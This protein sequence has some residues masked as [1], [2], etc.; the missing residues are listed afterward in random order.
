LTAANLDRLNQFLQ[1]PEIKKWFLGVATDVKESTRRQYATLLMRYF[2]DEKPADFLKRAQEKPKDIAIETKSRL[3]E[4]YIKSVQTARLTKYALKSFLEFH[5]VEVHMN[6]KL[7]VRRVRKKPEMKWEMAQK[8]I[9][10][11]DE[12]YRGLFTFMVNSGLGEDEVSEI[13][14]SAEIQSSIEEQR[15]NPYVKISLTPRKSNLDEYFTLCPTE[16]VP[17][18]PLKTRGGAL[19]DSMDMQAVWRRAAKK[20]GM[21]QVGLGP[22]QLRSA[23]RSQCGKADVS[24]AVSEFFMGHGPGSEKFGYSR[25]MLDLDYAL[26]EIS[27]LWTYNK[28]GSREA[29]ASM[30]AELQELREKIKVLEKEYRT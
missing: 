18:F 26:K 16:F 5:E 24:T 17:V 22:H 4:I 28:G 15:T 8:I 2:R 20:A 23:F 27:K 3:G 14:H 7:K 10:E 19:V 21:Y 9:A 11:S 13:Q 30:Q 25:E 29:Y 6:G 1:D 12:P